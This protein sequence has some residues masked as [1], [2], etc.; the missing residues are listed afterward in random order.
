MLPR[1][2]RIPSSEIPGVMRHGKRAAGEI[3]QIVTQKGEADV[4]PS[5]GKPR[6]AF[7]VST[8]ID[9]RA[10][11]RVRMKRLIS[12]S[13]FHLLPRFHGSA[14][15]IVIARKDF[16][17]MMQTEVEIMVAEIFQKAGLLQ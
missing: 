2:N 9:K 14:D 10:T 7:I 4:T 11:R 8:K 17:G 16:S 15:C 1:S 3:F 5:L 13:I 12:E 6:F